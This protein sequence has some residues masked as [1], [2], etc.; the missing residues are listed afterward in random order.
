M[1]DVVGFLMVIAAHMAVPNDGLWAAGRL[2]ASKL[3]RRRIKLLFNSKTSAKTPPT[4][5][6][7]L[8]LRIEGACIAAAPFTGDS[9]E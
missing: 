9:G 1:L 8:A 6:R 5:L 7:R 2:I 4:E 3:E